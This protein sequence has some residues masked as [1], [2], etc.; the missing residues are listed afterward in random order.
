M[1]L[2]VYSSRLKLQNPQQALQLPFATIPT[3]TFSSSRAVMGDFANGFFNR[4]VAIL[5][6]FVVIAINL[7]FVVSLVQEAELSAG[8]IALVGELK[9]FISIIAKWINKR[10]VS[11]VFG[12]AYIAFNAYLVLH[13]CS[14]LGFGRLEKLHFVKK[15]VLHTAWGSP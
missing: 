12:I 7:F 2:S 11:V 10:T 15:Y 5:L 8:Y 13:M 4:L 14:T 6:S 3:I 9:T 1:E